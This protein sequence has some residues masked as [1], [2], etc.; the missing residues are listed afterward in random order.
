MSKSSSSSK[1]FHF[2]IDTWLPVIIF[3]LV[4][5]IFG[6]ATGGQLYS[7]YNLK[8]IFS[9]TVATIIAGLGMIFVAAMGGT[10]ITCGVIV[11]LV[12]YFGLLAATNINPFMLIPVAL[13]IGLCSGLFLGFL[14]AKLKVSSFMASLAMLMGLRAVV[15]Y[16]LSNNSYYMPD[17]L[18]FID[19]FW[20]KLI[21]LI[22]LVVLII[23]IFHYT[24]FGMYVRAIGENEV[25]VQHA[26]VNVTAVKIGA[27]V[28][29]GVLASIAAIFTCAR[30]GGSSSTMGTGFEMKVMM[31]LF[32]AGVPV[33]GGYGTK[34]YKL[35][36][37]APTIMILENGLV[38]CGA[39]G[40]VTQLI[41]GL[42][43]LGAVSLTAFL[44]KRFANVG[45]EAAANQKVV[46]EEGSKS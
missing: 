5:V 38:L 6:I 8:S 23:Y 30:L 39:S 25:A 35:L 3:L 45:V 28:V 18:D 20:F 40:A 44:G 1:K 27:F 12:G 31:A 9:Q 24:R 15:T 42:V 46:A 41:R 14:N 32:I 33:Q 11:G 34:V 37:G 13:L 16:S 21:V 2:S 26:G 17:E 43:L 36:L 4:A 29:S 10:D 19:G 22:I 7:T